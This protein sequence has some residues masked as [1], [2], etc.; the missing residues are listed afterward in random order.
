MFK[1]LFKFY[2]IMVTVLKTNKQKTNIPILKQNPPESQILRR[3]LMMLVMCYL[4]GY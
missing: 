4:G 3:I 1:I 2:Y